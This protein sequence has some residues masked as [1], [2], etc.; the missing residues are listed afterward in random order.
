M[1]STAET[2][3]WAGLS[4]YQD[5]ET[6]PVQLKFCGRDNESFDVAQLIDNN[7]FVTLYGKSGTGKTS[8][9]NAGVFPR[10]RHEQYMPVS[11]RLSMD[12][13]GITFQQCIVDKVSQTLQQRHG[14]MSTVSV[15]PMP[16]DEQA[17]EYL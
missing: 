3:P 10:L 6:S 7:I 2:N 15:V 14:S 12:A 13:M 1:N 17:P 5:P 16:A 4:S 11:I 9:L 8:L